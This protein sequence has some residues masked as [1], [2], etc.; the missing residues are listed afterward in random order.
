M[1]SAVRL[2]WPETLQPCCPR[3]QALSCISFESSLSRAFDFLL[4][5]RGGEILFRVPFRAFLFES[6]SNSWP[7]SRCLEART[8]I[9][10][11]E[12]RTNPIFSPS[13]HKLQQRC[14]YRNSSLGHLDL[15]GWC[16]LDR[17]SERKAS[18]SPDLASDRMS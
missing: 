2:A 14:Q 4:S 9:N 18:P 5:A 8:Q 16:A 13:S 11:V 12:N 1:G 6:Q 3:T 10:G 7:S 15:G 17:T